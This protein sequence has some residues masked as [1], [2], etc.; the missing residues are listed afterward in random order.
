MTRTDTPSTWDE[1]STQLAMLDYTRQTVRDKC[2]GIAAEFVGAA[3]LAT[4]PLTSIGGLVNHMRWVEFAWIEKR[5]TGGPDLSPCTE[6]EPDREFTIGAQTPIEQTLREYDEQIARTDAIIA[7][8]NFDDRSQTP[9]LNGDYPTLRWVIL[10][11]IEENAR[12][13]GHVDI[14]RE[15]LDGTTGD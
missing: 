7:E 6:E 5:F 8:H 12:H 13:N 14:L 9:L 11:L 4:S 3:P 15:M 2:A 1:R 10:H